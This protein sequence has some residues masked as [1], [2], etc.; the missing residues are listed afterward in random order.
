MKARGDCALARPSLALSLPRL[1]S[2]F[3]RVPLALPYWNGETNR[4]ILRSLSSGSVI[5]GPDL[6]QLKLLLTATV[7]VAGAVLCGS[8]SLAL[9]LAL[10]ACGIGAGH[11]VVVPTF[12]CTTV[13]PPILASGAR[14]V[15]ADIGDNL[16]V[17]AA[18]IEAVLSE[19]TKAVIV[20]HLFGNPADISA[21]VDLL[22]GRNIRVIDDAAQ[23]LGAT[24]ADQPVGSFGDVGILSFGSEKV[25][26]GLGGGAVVSRNKDILARIAEIP[27]PPPGVLNS[28]QS[29][30]STI[31]WRRWRRW[32]LPLLTAL[33]HGKS[34][35]PDSPPVQYPKETMANLNAAVA[36]TLARRLR[37]NVSARRER[38]RAYQDL[39]GAERRLALIPHEPGSACLTQVVRVFPA[40]GDNDVSTGLIEALAREAYEV[41]GSYV[42]IHL[43]RRYE[44]YARQPLP[45]AER[46][47][48][49]LIEL[50]CEPDVSLGDV[51]RIAAIVKQTLKL[52]IPNSKSEI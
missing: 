29:L 52:Q 16:N 23:A 12:C 20:P 39:L 7:G 26:F 10:R 32:T 47:W 40:H 48:P 38:A 14:P 50:P 25:C 8:G 35:G 43:I 30:F 42:P 5:N 1:P 21:I 51:E 44:T 17:T 9:E 34:T 4:A 2:I 18:G 36:L 24:I 27:L 31:V 13:I 22:S 49:D 41:Q 6:N 28:L 45:N 33:F 19:K 15:L 46:V 11:E 3:P 37:E